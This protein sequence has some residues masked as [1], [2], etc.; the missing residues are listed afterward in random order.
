LAKVQCS[1]LVHFW[2][3]LILLTISSIEYRLKL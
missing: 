1:A 3:Q 2:I